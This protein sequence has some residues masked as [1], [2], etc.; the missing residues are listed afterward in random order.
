[1][2]EIAY[3]Q[4]INEA[5][6]EEMLRDEKVFVIGESIQSHVFF[7]TNGLV[8][9]FG[10]ERVMDTTIAETALAGAGIGAAMAGYR[11]VC[12]FVFSDFM[13]VAADEILIK[14][15]KWR[16][17]HGGKVK[18]PV[19]F[20]AAMGGGMR[21]GPEHSQSPQGY[22]MHTPGLKL[23]VPATPYDA[24][25]L[26]ISAIRDDN[27]VVFLYHKALMSAVGNVPEEPYAIPFGKAEIK[28]TG[29][30]VTVVAT[31]MMVSHSL[32]A[33]NELDGTISVEVIDPRTLQPLDM[34]TILASVRKTGRAVVVDEGPRCCGAT[35]EIAAQICEQ[36]FK[37]LEAPVQRV[38]A[39][40]LPIPGGI[41]EEHVLPQ[42][43][44][45][46]SAIER[47]M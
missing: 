24:K 47:V 2:R 17:I 16:A 41:A 37:T 36:A 40:N 33:A 34:D 19:V 20:M 46:I 6:R 14:A 8:E 27:P 18:I 4:A 15:A 1:M 21:L 22:F 44:D 25:G 29:T 26:M 3:I 5:L 11:P 31:S 30:D 35:A 23:A 9:E 39:A 10:P 13:F 32:Q 45:I 12:D 7:V 43:K 38:A 28:R 42:P